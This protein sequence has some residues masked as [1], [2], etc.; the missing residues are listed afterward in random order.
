MRSGS[1]VFPLER[2]ELTT[3]ARARM[4]KVEDVASFALAYLPQHFDLRNQMSEV[5][6]Q[7]ARTILFSR[8]MAI[9][10]AEHHLRRRMDFSEQCLVYHSTGVDV[11]DPFCAHSCGHSRAIS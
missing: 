9:G 1:N 4:T 10:L 5:Q 6:N 8:F 11:G 7:G 2:F 3:S